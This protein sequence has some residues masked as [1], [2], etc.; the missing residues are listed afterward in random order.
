MIIAMTHD[1]DEASYN[2][3]NNDGNN[4][5]DDND[6][7]NNNNKSNSNNNDNNVCVGRQVGMQVGGCVCV[8]GKGKLYGNQSVIN[9]D[10]I[11]ARL[12]A[13]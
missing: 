4:K 11:I 6:D 9:I 10:V 3:S 7:Y 5:N 1:Y 12:I 13:I 8:G 2:I